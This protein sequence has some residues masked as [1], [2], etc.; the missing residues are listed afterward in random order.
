MK[1][2]LHG[3]AGEVT[4]SAYLVETDRARVLIDLGMFQG[5]TDQD[6]KNVL[7]SGLLSKHLDAVLL[8]HGHLDHVG[9]LP[10]L[11]KAGYADEIYATGA[12]REL[13][14]LILRDSAKV[15]AYE[16]E[17]RNRKRHDAGKPPLQPLYIQ[18]DVER[19]MQLFRNVDYERP[20]SP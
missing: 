7:P 6:A 10:L 11:T 12:T 16:V 5:G 14:G 8:T 17:R 2:T 20:F 15:Q 4:G 3:A 1:V 18:E 19:V 13:A 9:R